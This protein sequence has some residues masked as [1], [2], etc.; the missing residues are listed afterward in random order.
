MKT[1]FDL[2]QQILNCW[3]ITDDLDLYN[4]RYDSMTEDQRMNYIIGLQELY[5]QKFER[6]W[7]TFEQLVQD[8]VL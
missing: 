8:K 7:N 1:R 4:E 3:N 6:M 5:N 2:E